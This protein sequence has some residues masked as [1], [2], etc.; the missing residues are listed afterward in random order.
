MRCR[1][2]SVFSS[3]CL[4][5]APLQLYSHFQFV[6]SLFRCVVGDSL[7]K[8]SK[9]TDGLLNKSVVGFLRLLTTRRCSHLLLW[10]PAV[11]QSIDISCWPGPQQ[12]TR[13]RGAPCGGQVMGQTDG[14]TPDGVMDP[15]P[16]RLRAASRP[17]WAVK[18]VEFSHTRYRALGPELIPVYR[19]SA[20]RWREVNH[21]IDLA[22]GCHYF[23]PGLRLPP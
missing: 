10:G 4:S 23:L 12:Q 21:A 3:V 9:A 7:F 20:R 6:Y 16:H 2:V 1:L 11:Q 19:Q 14:R 13:H 17:H 15:G 5:V 22:V 18:K 8:E